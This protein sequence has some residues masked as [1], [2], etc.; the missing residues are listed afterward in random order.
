MFNQKKQQQNSRLGNILLKRQLV[1]QNQLEQ[2][3]IFQQ[4]NELRLGEALLKMELI[5]RRQLKSALRK[6]SWLRVATTCLTLSLTPFTPAFAS[7]Q[8]KLDRT[9]TATTQISLT[10]L[11]DTVNNTNSDIS[12]KN[13]TSQISDGL[14][15]SNFNTDIYSISA[16]G[17]GNK[18]E[19]ILKDGDQE[20]IDYDVSYKYL[21]EEFKDIRG[22]DKPIYFNNTNQSN[23]SFGCFD[24]DRNRL[25]IALNDKEDK[26]DNSNYTGI[27][28]ITI[29]AE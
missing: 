26:V 10:I 28:T 3:L 2:A 14:C 19:F 16:T 24:A 7:T 5:D 29:A 23:S 20:E 22:S 9:S 17:S 1:T 11:P 25:K 15:T 27:L 12:F 13:T 4:E 18:G 8:G 21:G 6:Q